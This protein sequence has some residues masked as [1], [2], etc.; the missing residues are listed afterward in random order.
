MPDVVT[1]AL[2]NVFCFFGS[3]SALLLVQAVPLD[4]IC[5]NAPGTLRH[6]GEEEFPYRESLQPLVADD[7]DIELAA[8]DIAF[9][10]GVSAEGLMD[11]FDAIT[12]LVVIIDY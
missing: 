2:G 4:T 6:L 7:A 8:V 10:E 12:K 1:N 3:D 5:C 11:E 9:D